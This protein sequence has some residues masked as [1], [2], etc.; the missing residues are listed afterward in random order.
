MSKKT[1][2]S[3]RFTKIP[4]H[5]AEQFS[6][7]VRFDKKLA[8][9]DI[10]GSSAHVQM[11]AA[12]KIISGK[13]AKLILK[14][15]KEIKK[16]I[17]KGVFPF[18]SEYE[19]IHL[20]IEKR[21][22]EK[23]GDVGGMIHTARSRNDQ[24]VL[25]ERLYVRKQTEQILS[26]ITGVAD[27]IIAL[28]EKYYGV[29]M[30]LYTHLQRAQ[31]VLV[32]HHLLAY[33][34]ML[35]RDRMRFQG[36]LKRVNVNPLGACAG[37][38]TSFPIDR[39]LTADLLGFPSV[40]ANSIDTVSDRDFLAEFIFCSASLM[41]HLGRLSEELV[42]WSSL[43]FDFADLG[44]DFTT[45]SSIM[46]QKRNPDIAELVRGKGAR[47]NGNLVSILTLLKGLP[48]SYNRDMQE[49]KEPLFDT[50][51]TVADCLSVFTPML[52]GCKLKPENMK[53]SMS[54]GF[55]T[56]TDLA[57]YLVRGGMPFRKA[58]EVSGRIVAHAEK[59]GKNISEL[60][61]AEF[62]K[63]SPSINSDIYG[64]LSI[65]GSIKS[66]NS[67]GGTSPAQVGKMLRAARREISRWFG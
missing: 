38:G 54:E 20:N 6:A 12:R 18:R 37:A 51:Q 49:D 42:L 52:A 40:S 64:A 27:K 55:I 22:I 5:F 39:K 8:F 45:G 59:N 41:G 48:L 34:E 2:W 15:L 28:A 1:L 36:C 23:I 21:V 58:H 46:P 29:A 16:E 26:G 9:E 31:P 65:E 43:E 62:K 33:F 67:Q 7:S 44:D 50:A 4:H 13:N 60:T 30:P 14:S 3:G 53:K 17:E 57:D 63:F 19:D 35:K 24:I 25:D 61:F 11:L 32:S 10:E 56:A 47:V 66:R